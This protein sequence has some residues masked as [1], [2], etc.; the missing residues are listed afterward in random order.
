MESGSSD[1]KKVL[2]PVKGKVISL[3]KVNDSAFSSKVMGEGIAILPEENTIVAPFNGTVSALFPTKHAIGLTSEAG[4]ELLIHVGIDTVEL[5]GQYFES[6]VAV[7]DT[8]KA[9]QPLL[10]VDF[11][12]VKAA[13]YDTVIPIVVTNSDTFIDV[14]PKDEMKTADYEDAVLYVI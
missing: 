6:L 1:P 14:V 10:T 12:A 7:G 8:I 5:N 2:A 4:M 11:A 3:D 13:G 9:G